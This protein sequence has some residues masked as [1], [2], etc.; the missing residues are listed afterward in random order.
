MK[1]LVLLPLIFCLRISA[2]ENYHSTTLKNGLEVLIIE[3]HSVPLVNIEM[4]FKSGGFV[5][6]FETDGLSHLYE[7]MIFNAT[8]GYPTAKAF[9]NALLRQG[10]ILNA[11]TD[12]ELVNYY[13]TL[14]SVNFLRGMDLFSQGILSPLFLEEELENEKQIVNNEFQR[15]EADPLFLLD[16]ETDRKLWGEHFSRKNVIGDHEVILS[17][18]K[19]QLEELRNRYYHPN[20]ALLIIAGDINKDSAFMA[21]K[22]SFEGWIAASSDPHVTYP[23]PAFD[24]IKQAKRFVMASANT[25][26]SVMLYAWQG[27]D[28]RNDLKGLFAAQVFF[29]MINLRSSTFNEK[30]VETKLLYDFSARSTFSRYSGSL[31]IEAYPNEKRIT[32]AIQLMNEEIEQ[33]SIPTYFTEN[34]LQAAIKSIAIDESYDQELLSEYIHEVSYRWASGDILTPNAYL[35]NIKKVTLQDIR[36]FISDYVTDQ[37]HS[38]GLIVPTDQIKRM[39]LSGWTIE[40][41]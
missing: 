17:A 12:Q 8:E 6:T 10:I 32:K 31:Y 25:V 35:N 33:W 34:Q 16:R 28:C 21:A 14:P 18:Q 24:P 23:V 38:A 27:P 22:Q 30:L 40:N 39:K 4:A 29:R 15:A 1:Q 41:H 20:N 9:S 11:G 2:Q 3:D 13:F 26:E 5:E 36:A 7:H 37:P 19:E